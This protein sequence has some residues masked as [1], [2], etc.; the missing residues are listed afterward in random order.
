MDT[1]V[2]TPNE[3]KVRI[4]VAGPRARPQ[5]LPQRRLLAPVEVNDLCA[6]SNLRFRNSQFGVLPDPRGTGNLQG[7]VNRLDG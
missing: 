5:G 6:I 7:L 2:R 4:H 1:G 3:A